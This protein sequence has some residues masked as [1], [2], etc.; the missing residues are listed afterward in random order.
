MNTSVPV[1]PLQRFATLLN[2]F[3]TSLRQEWSNYRLD[4][5][6]EDAIQT[7][8]DLSPLP[9][10]SQ[11]WYAI[12][13]ILQT[14]LAL[15]NQPRLDM[16]WNSAQRAVQYHD[17]LLKQTHPLPP[18]IVNAVRRVVGGVLQSAHAN[19]L[20]KAQTAPISSYEDAQAGLQHAY[21]LATLHHMAYTSSADMPPEWTAQL[22]TV[23]LWYQH[24]VKASNEVPAT[25]DEQIAWRNALATMEKAFPSLTAYT[26]TTLYE[27]SPLLI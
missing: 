15:Q 21:Q 17:A 19:I 16:S 7:W 1:A 9:V 14:N 4:K 5:H 11:E 26:N 27:N 23:S 12:D 25:F 24:L 13:R 3:S 2:T 8:Q 20:H 10:H 6:V 18:D 22:S